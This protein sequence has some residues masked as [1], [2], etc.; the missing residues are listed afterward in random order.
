MKFLSD[1]LPVLLFF[2]TYWLTSDLYWATGVAVLVTV[3]Q[4]LY[5]VVM[6]KKIEWIQWFTVLSMLILG[7]ATLLLR[8]P[9]FVKWKP[10]VVNWGL[11]V[12]L[13]LAHWGFKKAPLKKLLSGHVT[14]PESIWS[15]LTWIWVGFFIFSGALNLFVAYTFSEEIWVNF[16]LFGLMGLTLIFVI[17]QSLYLSRHIQTE[18]HASQSSSE[19]LNS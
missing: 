10:T 6:R 18:T 19:D 2:L 15:R 7:G 17:G 3:V 13:A 1:L 16:K 12:A 5:A 14:L 9:Q 11:G 4:F 8:D